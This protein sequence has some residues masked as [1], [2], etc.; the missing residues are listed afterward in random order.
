[1]S[2][3]S[4]PWCIDT[5][6]LKLFGE[7]WDEQSAYVGGEVRENGVFASKACEGNFQGL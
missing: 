3:F 7:G 6:T 2:Y 1:M 4:F 5:I